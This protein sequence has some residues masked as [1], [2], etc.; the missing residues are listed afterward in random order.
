LERENDEIQA[1]IKRLRDACLDDAGGEIAKKLATLKVAQSPPKP[2]SDDALAN[3]AAKRTEIHLL[4]KARPN[5]SVRRT[6][7]IELLACC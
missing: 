3:D 1:E 4:E 7:A 2:L 5:R 6:L